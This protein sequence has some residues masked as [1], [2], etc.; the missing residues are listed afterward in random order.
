MTDVSLEVRNND[1][2]RP[3]RVQVLDVDHKSHGE[4]VLGPD[5]WSHSFVLPQGPYIIQIERPGSQPRQLVRMLT[6][7]QGLEVSEEADAAGLEAA[8][9]REF[10]AASR[11]RAAR[12]PGAA[13]EAARI[14]GRRAPVE[15]RGGRFMG[16]IL[17]QYAGRRSAATEVLG[18][19]V[20]RERNGFRLPEAR[21]RA[22]DTAGP[23]AP[24]GGRRAKLRSR[25]RLVIAEHVTID[26]N[27]GLTVRHFTS[28]PGEVLTVE[29]NDPRI[30]VAEGYRAPLLWLQERKSDVAEARFIAVPLFTFGVSLGFDADNRQVVLVES[31]NDGLDAL[32]AL[33]SSGVPVK[34]DAVAEQVFASD[35]PGFHDGM[36]PFELA[37]QL[38]KDKFLD[39]YAASVAGYFMIRFNKFDL[40]RDWSRNLADYF[41]LMSDGCIIEGW[42]RLIVRGD[43]ANPPWPEWRLRMPPPVSPLVP[44]PNARRSDDPVTDAANRFLEAHARGLPNFHY[45]LM[46]LLEGLIFC[47]DRTK[48]AALKDRLTGAIDDISAASRR[49]YSSAGLTT[50][51]PSF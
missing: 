49:A 42:R 41:P 33:L 12:L 8:G 14:G 39:P 1:V 23:A 51:T 18:Q 30:Q 34:A 11:E 45:G 40:L 3:V 20:S 6:A 36:D 47:F 10:E 38:M 26:P 28:V 35:G 46:K 37:Y 2:G 5:Q 50:I 27:I 15:R 44:E 32:M 43:G 7:D 24:A 48:D 13:S 17:S 19:G 16:S 9:Q 25:F 21:P 22:S 31:G 4:V 29:A